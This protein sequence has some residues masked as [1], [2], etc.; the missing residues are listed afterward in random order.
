MKTV[1]WLE[2]SFTQIDRQKKP[3][4]KSAAERLFGHRAQQSPPDESK[5]AAS[6]GAGYSGGGGGY[7]GGGGGKFHLVY[8]SERHV[9]WAFCLVIMI[10]LLMNN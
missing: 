6:P 9:K 10:A 2:Y 3:S 8:G 5:P 7:S 4:K 1:S